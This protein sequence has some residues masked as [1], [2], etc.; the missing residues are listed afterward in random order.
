M[1][2]PAVVTLDDLAAMN[3][4]DP[5]GHRYET[6][7]EA[8]LSVM[9]PPDSEHA[10]IASRLFAWLVMAGWPPE[11]VLQAVGVRIPGPEVR[12]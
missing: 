1:H 12:E 4:A 10:T 3:S 2:M 6:S 5:H 7:P 8:A 9:P 11:R